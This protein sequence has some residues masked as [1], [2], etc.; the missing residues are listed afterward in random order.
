M[1]AVALAVHPL[2]SVM[3]TVYDPA[4]RLVGLLP[5]AA[6]VHA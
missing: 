6:G 2:A 1:T 4:E 5:E 3:M